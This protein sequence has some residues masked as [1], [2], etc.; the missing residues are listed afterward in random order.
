[1][2]PASSDQKLNYN[3][4]IAATPATKKKLNHVF[5]KLCVLL[6]QL[7]VNLR[8]NHLEIKLLAISILDQ[9]NN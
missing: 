2:K 8:R 4:Q 3:I 5:Y 7:E 1:M 6:K 9:I